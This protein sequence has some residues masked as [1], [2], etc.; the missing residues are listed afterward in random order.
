[1]QFSI[2]RENLLTPLQ[3]VIGVV[4]RRQTLPILANVLVSLSEDELQ[5]I[6]T[7]LEV[8]LIC[9]VKLTEVLKT[10]QTTVSAKKLLDITRSLPEQSLLELTLDTNR[11]L[12][13]SGR[14]R[15]NLAVLPATD[16]PNSDVI[17]PEASFA[18]KS[19]ELKALIEYTH[20]CVAQQDVR[21]YLNGILIETMGNKLNLVATDGHRLAM[22]CLDGNFHL[23]TKQIILPRKCVSELMRL[24]TAG[25]DEVKIAFNANHFQCSF[26]SI[27]FKSRLIDGRFPNYTKVIPRQGNKQ[28]VLDKQQLKQAL[29]RV[30][31][32]ANEKSRGVRLQLRPNLLQIIANN[33]EQ[34]QAEE[35]LVVNYTDT[36]VDIGINVNYLMD[37]V[38]VLRS[39]QVKITLTDSTTSLL[40][41]GAEESSSL[42]VI[43]P[44]RL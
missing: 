34:E 17:T 8:E 37:V 41:Q 35:E 21:Y 16:F 11:L 12:V 24:L 42:Y 5:L 26:G 19:Q 9:K 36:E 2:S 25:E 39:E 15:F 27:T 23:D 43:M 20:F 6:G 40:I 28:L 29:L 10:G 31:V 32:L 18:L 30:A 1:M 33:N 3:A 13:R 7:D 44:M 4:E 14:S 22:S 38:N